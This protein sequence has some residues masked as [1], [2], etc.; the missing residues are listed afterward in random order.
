MAGQRETSGRWRLRQQRPINFGGAACRE[1]HVNVGPDQ[2]LVGS[3]PSGAVPRGSSAP[4]L[5]AAVVACV[6]RKCRR[7][8]CSSASSPSSLPGAQQRGPGR[9]PAGLCRGVWGDPSSASP[10]CGRQRMTNCSVTALGRVCVP[11][12]PEARPLPQG[13]NPGLTALAP[14]LGAAQPGAWRAATR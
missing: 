1:L 14:T 8:L 4:P 2:E 9:R 10:A 5:E 13:G 7:P 11:R 6:Q 3:L 12:V